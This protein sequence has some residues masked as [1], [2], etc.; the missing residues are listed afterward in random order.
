VGLTSNVPGL[1]PMND[2]IIPEVV[3]RM[4]RDLV[5]PQPPLPKPVPSAAIKKPIT[6]ADVDAILQRKRS[7]TPEDIEYVIS[8][9]KEF[10]LTDGQRDQL[11]CDLTIV[12]AQRARQG[13]KRRVDASAEFIAKIL[14]LIETP[15]GLVARSFVDDLLRHGSQNISR[16]RLHRVP[17]CA[18]WSAQR[19]LLYQASVSGERSPEGWAATRIRAALEQ[20]E[21]A[22]RP[23]TE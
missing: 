22:F 11:C 21:L 3:E 10:I 16:C 4:Y 14:G 8:H 7:A 20:L 1:T 6:R 12:A 23:E 13:N 19:A 17:N 15:F 2:L 9:A 18:C 5:R